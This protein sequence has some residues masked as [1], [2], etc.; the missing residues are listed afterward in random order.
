MGI[1]QLES[2]SESF[3]QAVELAVTILRK[4]G[5][6]VIPTETV[7]GLAAKSSSELAIERIYTL[8]G[9][10]FTKPLVV[11]I[12]DLEHARPLVCTEYPQWEILARAFWPGPLTIVV[13]A[14]PQVPQWIRR[15]VS[16]VGL[17][18]PNHNLLLTI[19]RETSFPLAITSANR[20]GSPEPICLEDVMKHLNG[21]PDLLIDSGVTELGQASTVVAV[22]NGQSRVL[23]WGPIGQVELERVLRVKLE[24]E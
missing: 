12:P 14:S 5:I 8:K 7:Y 16:S 6:I 1:Y 13:E 15:G 24:A 20:S 9:R 3:N 2:T 22:T 17:R 21:T 11:Q 18:C 4:N 10:S 23:R 19:L